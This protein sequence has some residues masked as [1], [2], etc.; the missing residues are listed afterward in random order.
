MQVALTALESFRGWCVSAV[1]PKCQ[2]PDGT[3]TYHF[4]LCVCRALH[5]ISQPSVMVTVLVAVARGDC[6]HWCWD[7]AALRFD[8]TV[9]HN[10][11]LRVRLLL[12]S[13]GKAI[14][15]TW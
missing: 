1:K 3:M 9:S 15:G 11:G 6:Y 5:S 4:F 14:I 7:T 12:D 8:R 10:G 2:R 13:S